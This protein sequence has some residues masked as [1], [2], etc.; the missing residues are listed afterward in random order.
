[1]SNEGSPVDATAC[2]YCGAHDAYVG[3]AHVKCANEYCDHFDEVYLAE[4]NELLT[5]TCEGEDFEVEDTDPHWVVDY[6][7]GF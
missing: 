5:G 3:F 1:M 2:P 4:L 7:D 6:L